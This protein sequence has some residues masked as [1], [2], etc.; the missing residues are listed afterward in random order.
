M[1]K[2]KKKKIHKKG[3][4]NNISIYSSKKIILRCLSV[5]RR[6]ASRPR[7]VVVK[8]RKK[9]NNFSIHKNL[10]NIRKKYK[11]KNPYEGKKAA[12][13]YKEKQKNVTTYKK[14]HSDVRK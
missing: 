1:G 13:T 4:E 9:E 14:E 8:R 6:S 7:Y 3:S 11:N 5:S 10:Q 12:T 2:R